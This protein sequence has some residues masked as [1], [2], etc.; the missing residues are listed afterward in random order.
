MRNL[1]IT[2]TSSLGLF[3]ATSCSLLLDSDG[4]QCT[5]SADCNTNASGIGFA[6]IDGI[7]IGNQ[8]SDLCGARIDAHVGSPRALNT[9]IRDTS[10]LVATPGI[11]QK[12]C[13]ARDS[14]CREPVAS[15]ISNAN[16]EAELPYSQGTSGDL[17][18]RIDV[19]PEY[20]PNR[21]FFSRLEAFSGPHPFASDIGSRAYVEGTYP[22]IAGAPYDPTKG[23]IVVNISDCIDQQFPVGLA[24]FT[25]DIVRLDGQPVTNRLGYG[26][27]GIPSQIAD[28]TVDGFAILPNADPG[29]YSVSAIN[30]GSGEVFAGPLSIELSADEVGAAYLVP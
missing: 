8:V 21:L 16:G 1:F 3:W 29:F 25:F 22:L 4:L 9:V 14:A 11:V 23:T 10:T 17:F 26:V 28:R 2:V 5:S 30:P 27:N 20:L 24:G 13:F 18:L 19:P 15:A 6:C 12:L 7:C